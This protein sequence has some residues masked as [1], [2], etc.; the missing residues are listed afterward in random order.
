MATRL[1]VS[2]LGEPSTD[3]S[4]RDAFASFGAIV[5]ATVVRDPVTWQMHGY[6]LVVFDDDADAARAIVEMN[7]KLLDGHEIGV[8]RDEL[9]GYPGVKQPG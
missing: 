9:P 5:T 8:R 2:G 3:E 6:G 7:G 4:L 1:V